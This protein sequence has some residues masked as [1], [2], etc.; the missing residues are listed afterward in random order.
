[1]SADVEICVSLVPPSVNRYV[2]HTRSGRH[3]VTAEALAFKEAVG[4]FA[5]GARLRYKVGKGLTG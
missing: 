3:Y 2:R 1:M 5:R 4:L